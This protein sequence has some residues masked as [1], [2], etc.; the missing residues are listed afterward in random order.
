[1]LPDRKT[2][3]ALLVLALTMLTISLS[4]C[5]QSAERPSRTAEET[6]QTKKETTADKPDRLAGTEWR[7]LT[8]R[9]E[10]LVEDSNITLEIENKEYRG[11]A[12]CNWYGGNYSAEDG[13]LKIVGGDMTSM[14]NP[15]VAACQQESTYMETLSKVATYQ[16]RDN[17]LE[18]KNS[19]DETILV[20]ARKPPWESDPTK[21]IDTR[22]K[23]SSL[24][25]KSPEKGS[26]PTL[27]FESERRYSGYNGCRNLYGTYSVDEDDLDFTSFS[28]KD[29]GCIK[30]V[31]PTMR[32]T[33]ASFPPAGDYRLNGDRLEIRTVDGNTYI[34]VPLTEESNVA[35]AT[36]PWRL[37]KFV[38]SGR[39]TPVLEGTKISIAFDGGT[40]RKRGS[41]RG[42]AGCNRY[43]AD[44]VYRSYPGGAEGPN[45]ENFSVTRK[46]CP[47]PE[48]VMDQEARYLSFL[49][50]VRGYYQKID[51]RLYLET[52]DGRK[53]V[54]S[55]SG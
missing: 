1:M 32:V 52:G 37:E 3:F 54:F 27:S 51:G 12:G 14:G 41:A 47:S 42:S 49:R 5:G 19:T 24:N 15:S 30:P 46:L 26:V 25:G 55:G 45:F 50:D 36:M 22:W 53:L 40:L 4:A 2:T 18:L 38:E 35:Q 11:F 20:F 34:F 10:E 23:L 13:S 21:L 9:G 44:Y 29:L 28:M 31:T 39:A 33:L 17:R 48:G 6:A 7:L 16:M 8:L 43:T